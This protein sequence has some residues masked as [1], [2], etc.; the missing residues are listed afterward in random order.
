MVVL[1]FGLTEMAKY[2]VVFISVFFLVALNTVAGVLNLDTKYFDIAKN[3]GAR[4]WDMI[5]TVAL[6]G[7]L[8]NILTGV[9]LGL[10]FALTV[11]VGTELLLPQSGLGALI[12]KS[13]QIY[14]IPT[15]FATLIVV[16]LLGWAINVLMEEVERQLVPWK[17]KLPMTQSPSTVVAEPRL[18]RFIRIWWMAL[19][20]FSFTASITPVLFGTTL[21]LYDGKFNPWYALITLLGSMAIHGGTNLINDY[22]DWVKGTDT[23]ESLGP[24]RPLKEGL[25]TIR[26]VFVAAIVC[27]ALGSGIGLYLVAERGIII[28]WLGIFSV[29]AGWFY[30]AGP[31]A[32]AYVGLG[33]VIVFIFMGPIMVLGSYFVQAQTMPLSVLLASFPLGLIVAAILHAN[34]MRD[35]AD[36]LAKGKRTLAN[37]LGRAMSKREYEILTLGCWVL[38]VLLVVI[39]QIHWLALLGLIE[40]PNA[41][42]LVRLA[43]STEDP[44]ALNALVRGTAASHKRFGAWLILGVLLGALFRA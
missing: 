7:A 3:N 12:W 2:V 37:L 44:K 38:L 23:P 14:D 22:Y 34:N 43:N 19:R 11:I 16:A 5:W 36:D 28:L 21:A 40:L 25:I 20:P 39:Q 41:L 27:F 10:G 6:P 13:Y 35:F 4:R 24:N 30:T 29:L 32:F 42:K 8:P 9:N 17:A 1:L 26:Q 15:I 33:E 18:R 31:V